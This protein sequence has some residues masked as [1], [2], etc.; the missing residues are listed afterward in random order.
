MEIERI[1]IKIKKERYYFDVAILVDKEGFLDWI[2]S[3]RDKWKI[4][5]LFDPNDY[6]GFY[7]YIWGDIKIGRWN[8][9]SA[10]VKK[11]RESFNRSPNF[12]EV[13]IYAL[14]FKYIP[15]GTYKPCYL[16][17]IVD[18]I[19]PNSPE[20]YKYAIIVTPNTT[21]DDLKPILKEYQSK[22][23]TGLEQKSD[24]S[25]ME[26]AVAKYKFELGPHYVPPSRKSD[27]IIRDRDWYWLKEEGLS[28]KEILELSKSK[29]K[30]LDITRDG[31]ITAIKSYKKRL[32]KD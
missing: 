19:D 25:I 12:D 2:K 32:T 11:V 27:N 29:N 7:K 17:T 22:L 26:K 8:E 9:F 28:Y 13:I 3:L 5:S 20:K 30:K 31:I 15:D 24:S 1:E 4:K 14:A 10:D 23:A 18:P 6:H 16:E 21:I